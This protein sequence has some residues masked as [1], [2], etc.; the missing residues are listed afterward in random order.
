MNISKLS[1]R[2]VAAIFIVF[3]IFVT[4]LA[5]FIDL[6]PAN[7][8]PTYWFS[9]FDLLIMELLS[10][11]YWLTNVVRATTQRKGWF[12]FPIHLS[13][14]ITISFFFAASIFI[15]LMSMSASS[16]GNNFTHALIWIIVIKWVSMVAI[17]GVLGLLGTEGKNQ[18]TKTI[19]YQPKRIDITKS[20]DN[21]LNELRSLQ[22]TAADK[23]LLNEVTDKV[24]ILRNKSRSLASA[25]PSESTDNQKIH[26]LVDTLLNITSQMAI[27]ASEDNKQGL[28]Q[29]RE[30]VIELV[31]LLG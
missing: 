11:G 17:I 23:P 3:V 10:G 8:Q 5:L 30:A 27:A 31:H 6:A 24:E 2:L 9:M 13:V 26:S 29:S 21:I 7:P 25:V 4:T 12:P 19:S 14:S 28:I 15:D 1:L 20:V 22:V 16:G 18:E